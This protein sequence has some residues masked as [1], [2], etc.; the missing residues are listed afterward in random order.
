MSSFSTEFETEMKSD[1]SLWAAKANRTISNETVK[2]YSVFLMPV[3][4]E[5]FDD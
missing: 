5:R 4:A 2:V 3:T 1:A